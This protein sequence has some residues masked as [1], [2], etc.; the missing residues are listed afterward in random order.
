L[1]NGTEFSN[2]TLVGKHFIDMATQAN[3]KGDYFPIYMVCNGIEMLGIIIA[4]DVTT[5]FMNYFNDHG[6]IHPLVETPFS[7]ESRFFSKLPQD[8]YEAMFSEKLTYFAHSNG[9]TLETWVGNK[10]LTDF[11]NVLS[12]TADKD[13][14]WFISTIEAKEYPIYG[15]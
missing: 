12:I 14:K 13:G 1:I 11:F 5:L 4:E 10:K 2:Y 9:F 3:D 7:R 6:V 15:V 8:I